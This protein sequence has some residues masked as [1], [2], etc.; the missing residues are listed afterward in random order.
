MQ[1]NQE[2]GHL[3][4]QRTKD[5]IAIFVNGCCGIALAISMLLGLML[6]LTPE[7]GKDA[8]IYHIGVPKMFLEHH[9]IYFIPGNIFAFYPFFNEMLY[10]WGLSL[11]G[12]VVPKG[13]HFAMCGLILFGMLRFQR[14]YVQKN[15]FHWLPLL[16]FFT[17]PS[18]FQNAHVAY[19]DLTLAFY[20]L[21]ALYAF[22]NWY[23]TQRGIWIILCGVFS[24]VAMSTKYAGLYMPLSGCFGILWGCR[25]KE[26]SNRETFLLLF[27]YLLFVLMAGTPFYLKNWIMTGNP[28]YPLFHQIFGGR[29]WSAEQAAYYDAFIKSLGMGRGLMDY[30]LLPWNLSFHA[31]TNSSVFDGLMGPLFILVLPFAV[32]VRRLGVEMKIA[33]VYCLITFG[34]W[35][36]SAQQ[37]RYL[38]PLFPFLAILAGLTI[39]YYRNRKPILVLLALFMAIGLLFN[40]YHIFKDFRSIR[41]LSVLVGQEDRNAFLTRTIPAY[42]MIRYVN[43][44][45]PEECICIYHLHET[46]CLSV[47]SPLLFRRH[48]RIL[49]PRKDI[50]QRKDPGGRAYGP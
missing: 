17:I 21:V 44:A 48:V 5:R 34:F 11:G 1:R 29:G 16:I 28:L 42:P 18:V 4:N 2:P 13:I 40:G 50:E 7:I 31:K 27:Q 14:R 25:Q 33:L 3:E 6:L 38:I 37:M 24:G 39:S 41:P 22:L 15:E 49:Y 9:G 23:H 35:A 19:C 32:G 47:Q 12:E 10:T 36:S 20:T 43:T 30:L 26:R 46:S 45:T 8:L